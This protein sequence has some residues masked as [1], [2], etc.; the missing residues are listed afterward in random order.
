MG[1]LRYFSRKL[2]PEDEIAET[3]KEREDGVRAFNVIASSG[4]EPEQEGTHEKEGHAAGDK[5]HLPELQAPAPDVFVAY[6][7]AQHRPQQPA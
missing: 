7:G 3:T 4:K 5:G 6:H 1:T 2:P